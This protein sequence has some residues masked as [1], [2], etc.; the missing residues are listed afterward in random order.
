MFNTERK[1]DLRID[2]FKKRDLRETV[3]NRLSVYC[4]ES[5]TVILFCSLVQG[6]T[7]G[8]FMAQ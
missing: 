6:V 3:W 2:K 8:V 5:G 7:L 4:M 1:K